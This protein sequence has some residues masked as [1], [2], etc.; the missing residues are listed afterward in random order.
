MSKIKKLQKR[1]LVVDDNLAMRKMLESMLTSI[2]YNNVSS[3]VD[4]ES[5]WEKIL[6][7][8]VDIV[9][10]DY[11]MPR[12]NGLEFLHR[13]RRSKEY[14]N[15][16]FIMI[17]G[18][19]NWGDFMN[20]VQAEVDNYLI[21]PI[22]ADRLE[23]VLNQVHLQQQSA[24]PY[25]KA[26]HTGKHCYMNNDLGKA[27]KSFLLAQAIEPALAKPYFYLGQIS[28]ESARDEE[29]VKFFKR[30]LEIEGNYIN[31]MVGLVEIYA[32]ADDF[33]QMFIYLN[34]ALEVAPNNID[35]HIDLAKASFKLDDMATVRKALKTAT[36]IAKSN[37]AHVEK[38][39][40]SYIGCG[41]LDEADY[42]FGKK[43]QDDD[44]ETVR[45][46]NRLGLEAKGIGDFQKSKYFYLSA[47]KLRPQAKEVNF[48][49]AILLY[50]QGE[51]NSSMAYTT[52]A[53]RLYPDFLEAK[54]L[55][56]SLR[57]KIDQIAP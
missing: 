12:L 33:G 2:G 21:K 47:L 49:I 19:D 4:G 13:I 34:K 53:L 29:A 39:I 57:K 7:G 17:T 8:E 35:L 40:E 9:I 37:K 38:V 32:K 55:M 15:L 1:L 42:L 25:L 28:K 20:T 41:L 52:K 14:F 23:E 43:L 26:M 46:W 51:Y 45:F 48:N 10:S 6:E 44:T 18:A 36:K 16:P 54:E 27:Y 30:C 11:I 24:S 56:D 31:A 50:E 3:A 5:G 22:T